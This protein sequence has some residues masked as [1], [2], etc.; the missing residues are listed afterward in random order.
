[1]FKEF[2][3]PRLLSPPKSDPAADGPRRKMPRLPLALAVALLVLLVGLS[4]MAPEANAQSPIH[5]D[6]IRTVF[7][8]RADDLIYRDYNV[9]EGATLSAIIN[10]SQTTPADATFTVLA[11]AGT[12]TPGVDF[13]AGIHTFTVP[14]GTNRHKFEIPIPWDAEI[15]DYE[16]FTLTLQTAPSRYNLR[17]KT[18]T[19]QIVNVARVPSDWTLNPSGLSAGDQYRLLFKTGNN[20]NAAS[21]NI[22]NYDAFVRNRP[23]GHPWHPDIKKYADTFRVL[24]C[25]ITDKMS[26]SWRTATGVT[27]ESNHPNLPGHTP[28]T[29]PIYWM[30]GVQIASDYNKFWTGLWGNANS[31]WNQRHAAGNVASNTQFPFIGCLRRADDKSLNQQLAGTYHLYNSLGASNVSYGHNAATNSSNNAIQKGNYGKNIFAPYLGIS[32][33]HQVGDFQT[34]DPVISIEGI[35]RVGAGEGTERQT[36]FSDPEFTIRASA[37][38]SSDLTINL[39]VREY[40]AAGIDYVDD[41]EEG[42]RT[43]VI[44]AG[45]QTATFTVPTNAKN[46]DETDGLVIASIQPGTGYA[47]ADHAEL[48]GQTMGEVAR[49]RRSWFA[50]EIHTAQLIS[51]IG[52]WSE[53][54]SNANLNFDWAQMFTTGSHNDGYTVHS[55][56]VYLSESSLDDLFRTDNPRLEVTIR[57]VSNGAPGKTVGALTLPDSSPIV[58]WPLTVTFEAPAK[59]IKLSPSTDYYF[60]IDVSEQPPG[61]ATKLRIVNSDAENAGGAT[62]F[63]IGNTAMLLANWFDPPRW[64]NQGQGKN[65]QISVNGKLNPITD[66]VQMSDDTREVA[67]FGNHRDNGGVRVVV[68]I[69]DGMDL[70]GYA[71]TVNFTTAGSADRGAGKDYTIEGCSSSTCTMRL[72]ANRHS[73]M[74]TINVNDDGIDEGDET[75]V[76]TLE[77][78]S[79]YT[80]DN[81]RKT[82]TLTVRDDDTRGL[83]FSRSW[84]D[85]DEGAS[86]NYTVN[87]RSQPTSAVTINIASD[88]PDV[89]VTPTSL[90]FNPSGN[91][92]WSRARTV[93]VDAAQDSDTVDDTAILTHTT[94]GGDYGGANALSI[95]RQVSV[96]DDD[97]PAAPPVIQLPI[98]SITGGDA[99]TEGGLAR[100]TVNA[101]RA[102]TSIITVNVE[103]A[104]TPEQDF[105]AASQERVWTVTLNAGATSTPFI[106]STVNDNTI[107][108]DGLVQVFVN[109]GAGYVAGGGSVVTVLDNDYSTPA[110]S[111][112][113][114]IGIEREDD[115]THEAR[116]DLTHPAPPGGITLQ[117]SVSGTATRGSSSDYTVPN[118]VTVNEGERSAVIPVTINDDSNFEAEA[119]TVILTLLRGA[120]YTLDGTTVYTLTITDNDVAEQPSL[121]FISPYSN[122]GEDAGVHEVFVDLRNPAPFDGITLSYTVSGTATAG[123]GNDFTIQNSGTVSVLGG[124]TGAA[125]P[126]AI[127][128]DS[129]EESPETVILTLTASAGYTLG[130][131]TSHTVTIYDNDGFTSAD[132][133]PN[134]GTT[135]PEGAGTTLN[136]RFTIEK[137]LTPGDTATLPLTIWGTATPGEDYRL[138]CGSGKSG[139]VITCSGLDGYS[140]S[141][142]FDGSG[143]SGTVRSFRGVLNLETLEDNTA[144]SPDETLTLRLGR[145]SPITITIPDAPSSVAVSFN[146]ATYSISE[147]TGS[148]QLIFTVTPASGRALMIPLIYTDVTATNGADYTSTSHAVLK[149]NGQ[150]NQSHPPFTPILEDTAVEGSE[151]FRVAI[152][153]AN[154]PAGVTAGAITEATITITDND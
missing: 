114:E 3:S 24:G 85:I 52:Q 153:T 148:A 77:D 7:Y 108:D 21:T 25:T 116:V 70:K 112:S 109:D 59:G 19:V 22:N 128:D 115:G 41:D 44:P 82:F 12:A 95:G 107:E 75:I 51:N 34:S 40:N 149:A 127:N 56:D 29:T 27:I 130:D 145:G 15:E 26:A 84:A 66:F 20:R 31:R 46:S 65:M 103:V 120:R 117:Y 11:E 126:I 13:P 30:N 61:G 140:A 113:G 96:E 132:L 39:N 10:F 92:R 111:F 129:S 80:V 64:I 14:S 62:G 55:V 63:S 100:F 38:P 69:G 54:G 102:P 105:V 98:I 154:L 90:T 87:L 123:S 71:R 49:V 94:S 144:E 28:F 67:E 35:V 78:G 131:A 124:A 17:N 18:A 48:D 151:T 6:F 133:N 110:V 32:A 33:V 76:V 36:G 42:D 73:G 57:E 9:Q 45:Q 136:A 74:L 139:V 104:E 86:H 125:I 81:N 60:V 1:M 146:R 93:T 23:D 97:T 16:T 119:E 106:V 101:N 135:L 137:Q 83:Y 68:E 58:E 150:T 5:V 122:A 2:F 138:T 147:G 91:S 4:P 142:T 152:D 8:D 72:P 134:G 121:I 88:N 47:I 143:S 53:G 43:I 37:A 99:V 50:T 118:A 89:T 79:G 141:I